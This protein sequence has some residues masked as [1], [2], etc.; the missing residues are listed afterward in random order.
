M[1]VEGVVRRE[2]VVV[3]KSVLS[4]QRVSLELCSRSGAEV[5]EREREGLRV[6]ALPEQRAKNLPSPPCLVV[7]RTASPSSVPCV[8]CFLKG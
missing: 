6:L 3:E 2:T 7:M 1:R 8:A 4:S 5:S